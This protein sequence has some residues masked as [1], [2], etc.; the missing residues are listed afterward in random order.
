MLILREI[1]LKK[2]YIVLG[3]KYTFGWNVGICSQFGSKEILFLKI[4]SLD[5]FDFLYN[6]TE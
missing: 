3:S 5:F 2:L 1:V 6:I 4:S